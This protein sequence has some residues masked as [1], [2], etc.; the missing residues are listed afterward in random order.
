MGT[1][2]LVFSSIWGAQKGVLWWHFSCC[3]SQHLVILEP[4]NTTKQ[5]KTQN[6]KSTLFTPPQGWPRQAFLSLALYNSPSL[7]TVSF[8]GEGK[9]FCFYFRSFG[10]LAF[11]SL[12]FVFSVQQG[13]QYLVFRDCSLA[14]PKNGG[15]EGQGFESI[16]RMR[17]F[18]QWQSGAKCIDRAGSACLFLLRLPSIDEVRRIQLAG[19]FLGNLFP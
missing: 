13:G 9:L 10:S 11:F 2:V 14:F 19:Y 6:A 1:L 15:K 16:D 18:E 7:H 8:G 17:R 12:V 5:G 3:F 4:P